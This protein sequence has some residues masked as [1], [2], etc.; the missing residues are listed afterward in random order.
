[1]M[2]LDIV[3]VERELIPMINNFR[4][5][6]EANKIIAERLLMNFQYLKTEEDE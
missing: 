1:M 6:L 5:I 4:E 3:M 2:Q